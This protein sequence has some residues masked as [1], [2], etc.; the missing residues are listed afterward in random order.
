MWH[1]GDNVD[2]AVGGIDET[3][4][5]RG[6]VICWPSHSVPVA[7]KFKAH[8]TTLARLDMPIVPGQQFTFHSHML[9]EPCNVSRLLRTLDK[10]GHTK[11]VRW[12]TNSI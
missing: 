11:Q 2:V 8:I 7:S 12:G 5:A 10:D 6:Q 9:E 1:A 3:A 4:L